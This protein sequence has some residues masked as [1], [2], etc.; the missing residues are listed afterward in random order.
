MPGGIQ[1][2]INVSGP[3]NLDTHV[4]NLSLFVGMRETSLAW[5]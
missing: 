5:I 2:A 3:F 1:G 4:L